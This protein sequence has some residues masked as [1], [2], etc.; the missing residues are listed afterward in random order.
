[1]HKL[2]LHR[3]AVLVPL[4]LAVALSAFLLVR[5][6]PGDF[7]AEL[8][9]NPQVSAQTLE[10]LREQYGL[11]QPWYRQ[12]GSWLGGVVRGDWGYSLSCHCPASQL[13]TERL[14][15]T[16]W[17]ALSGLGLT[18][19]LAVPL[20]L[21]AAQQQA[22]RRGG[23]FNRALAVLSA[24][25]QATPAFLLALLAMVLAARSGWFP[26]GGVQSLAAGQFS[27]AGRWLDFAHHLILPASVLALR[28]APGFFRQVRV[29]VLETLGQ[30]F[31]LT[32]RAKGLSEGSIVL[33]HALRYALPPTLAMLG[34]SLGSLLSGAF[35]VEAVMS[36][37]GLGSLTVNA[38]LSRDLPLLVA[39]L[40]CAALV[41]ALGNLVA[42]VL[43][44][45]ADPRVR[46]SVA[47]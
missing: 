26:L 36:W 42:D 47:H 12:F 8:S 46:L 24:L 19:A 44:V 27:A 41:L 9:L 1:M 21:L 35:I 25:C 43:L 22:A 3:I 2:I 40:V 18:L 13:L 16:V 38:L 45:W 39:C 17:L 23:W 31:I 34:N 14:A 15:N 5:L 20:G 10:R 28:Q 11:N 7:V 4:L 32:A 30:D 33:K 37:P 29:S 6:A